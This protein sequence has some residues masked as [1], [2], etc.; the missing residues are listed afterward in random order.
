MQQMQ[1]QPLDAAKSFTLDLKEILGRNITLLEQFDAESPE[2][3]NS[4]FSRKGAATCAK[5]IL[6]AEH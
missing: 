5:Y 1:F 6:S 3:G 2:P 4:C